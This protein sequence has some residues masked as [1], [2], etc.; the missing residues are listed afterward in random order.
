[1][2]ISDVLAWRALARIVDEFAMLAIEHV[3]RVVRVK[4]VVYG[5]FVEVTAQPFRRVANRR[6]VLQS[7]ED[8]S[9]QF[10]R[11][12]F[13]YFQY[14]HLVIVG[15]LNRLVFRH[16]GTRPTLMRD[17][18]TELFCNIGVLS[19]ETQSSSNTSSA[20][21]VQLAASA[22]SFS[23]FSV[24][25]TTDS[26]AIRPEPSCKICF[27]HQHCWPPRYFTNTNTLIG[28]RKPRQFTVCI[29]WHPKVPAYAWLYTWPTGY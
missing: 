5:V 14:E 23:S 21:L 17:P 10:R 9:L 2:F 24:M 25:T 6:W 3:Q 22:M 8:F 12:F 7:R 13:V 27:Q 29:D 20:K 18:G 1:M 28:T 19:V 16:S 15:K 11:Y 4:T 26:F